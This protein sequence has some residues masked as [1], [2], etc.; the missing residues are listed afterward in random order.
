MR[1]AQDGDADDPFTQGLR[2]TYNNL[3]AERRAA[4]AAVAEFDAA[5]HAAPDR[6]TADDA[7]LLDDLPCLAL[8]LADAPKD[9]LRRL[10][11]IT[12][13]TVELHDGSNDVTITIR[14]P[15]KNSPPSPTRQKGSPP[16]PPHKNHLPSRH[17]L[18]RHVLVQMQ[19]VPPAGDEPAPAEPLA[20]LLN[21]GFRGVWGFIWN[22]MWAGTQ[23]SNLRARALVGSLGKPQLTATERQISQVTGI[24]GASGLWPYS[25]WRPSPTGCRW[26]WPA[27]PR[28][29]HRLDRRR[30]G[31][32][33]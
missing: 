23:G 29:D 22:F 14:L 5:D 3:E 33:T 28:C 21:W 27:R 10:F 15:P 11:E 13:L 30:S 25:D 8:N 12:N 19:F 26:L 17:A 9:L 4:L 24:Q 31:C 32:R 7:T 1:Q 6:P 20:H 2:Q 16:C 18:S